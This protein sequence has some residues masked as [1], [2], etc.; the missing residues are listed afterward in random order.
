MAREDSG[1]SNGHESDGQAKDRESSPTNESPKVRDAAKLVYSSRNSSITFELFF[2]SLKYLAP[3]TY[4]N[5]E[6][7]QFYTAFMMADCGGTSKKM[8]VFDNLFHHLLCV[9]FE[10]KST[11]SNKDD[12]DKHRAWSMTTWRQ[13][14]N[15]YSN[16]NIFEKDFLIFPVCQDSHWFAIVVCYPNEVRDCAQQS[17]SPESTSSSRNRPE[18]GIMILDSLGMDKTLMSVEVRYFLDFEWRTRCTVIKDFF[19]HNLEQYHPKLPKQTNAYDCGIFMFA[20]LRAF[21]HNPERFYSLVRKGRNKEAE[22]ELTEMVNNALTLC[23]REAIKN[24]IRSRC[25][26]KR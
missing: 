3:N 1:Q 23:G 11:K 7:I 12:A 25:H 19:Y 17:P 6:I 13:L 20:Y 24:L 8:H 22:E 10:E 14:E 26:A 4:L 5:D 2:D 15:W 9:M 21:V 16:I 18:P